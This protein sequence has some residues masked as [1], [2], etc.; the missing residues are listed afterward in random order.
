MGVPPY[1]FVKS[2][3]LC[4][5]HSIFCQEYQS[6]GLKGD[7]TLRRIAPNVSFELRCFPAIPFLFLR[8]KRP[9]CFAFLLSILPVGST[10]CMSH[11]N[12]EWSVCTASGRTTSSTPKAFV[13]Q[14]PPQIGTFGPSTA[15]W[16]R[17]ELGG[18]HS[19]IFLLQLEG[20]GKG[21]AFREQVA[22]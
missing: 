5:L 2:I 15:R 17:D 14:K 20:L 7:F 4:Y 9:Q 21:M 3:K 18:P 12:R 22:P 6:Q 16:P 13:L 10:V 1:F 19:S 11:C 8:R